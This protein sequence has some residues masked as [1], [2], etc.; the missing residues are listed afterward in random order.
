MCAAGLWLGIL[1]MEMGA[2][3]LSGV[4]TAP[5]YESLV[6]GRSIPTETNWGMACLGAKASGARRL[7]HGGA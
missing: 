1:N 4:S 2:I 6:L 7:K 3:G 5:D